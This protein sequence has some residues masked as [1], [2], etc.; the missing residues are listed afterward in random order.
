MSLSKVSID[1]PIFITCI[2]IVLLVVGY[3]SLKK[4]PVDLFPDVEIP[5]V[6]VR[7]DYEGSGPQ[8]IETQITKPMEDVIATVAGIETLR[9]ISREGSSTIIAEFDL[10]V[11]VKYAEQQIR[12]RVAA[13]KY[14]LPADVLDPIIRSVDPSD[15]PVI[16]FSLSADLPPAELYD[17]ANEVVKP[18]LTQVNKVGQV[19]ILGGRR[20]EIQVQLDRNKLFHYNL[21]A[22]AVADALKKAGQNTPIGKTDR[23]ES[24]TAYRAV[25]EFRDP[26]KVAKT[27]VRFTGNENPVTIRDV[28]TVQDTLVD[29]TSRTFVNG[30]KSLLIYVFRQSKA[31]TVAVAEGLK[32]KVEEI[33]VNMKG[34]PGAP[35]LKVVRDGAS[36]IRANIADVNESILIG[37]FL[38]II[39]VYFFLG[40]GRST[41]ITGLALPNSLLGA[42]ILMAMAGFSINIM[43]LLALSLTVG[44]LI[45][46]AI[47]VRENIFR[48]FEMGKSARR[49]AL[50][51]T[52]EVTLAV[53][54]TTLAILA[55]FGPIGFLSGIVGQ[56]LKEFGL[57]V[58]FAMLISLFDAL[59]IAPM[60]SAYFAR[61]HTAVDVPKN[62]ISRWNTNALKWFDRFQTNLENSY[63]NILH[64][65]LKHPL[66]VIGINVVIFVG[67]LM[68]LPLIPKTFIPPQ[69]N[70]EFS[71]NLD[72]PAGT[73]LEAM[74]KLSSEVDKMLRDDKSIFQTVLTVG[75]SDLQSNVAEIFIKLVPRDQRSMN[76]SQFKDVVREKLKMYAHA[77][78]QVSDQGGGSSSGSG[79]RPFNVNII[80]T[81]LEE[82]EKFSSELLAKLKKFPA[83][84]DADSS[85]R[86]GKPEIRFVPEPERA[87]SLGVQ[88]GELG[89]ELRIYVQGET[90]AVFRDADREYDV[91][92]RLKEDQRTLKN[93]YDKIYVPNINK[94]LVPLK[95]AAKVEESRSANIILRQDRARYVQI[96]GD[97]DPKG[98][99]IGGTINYVTELFKGELKPPAG[100][101]Y[102]FVGQAKRF[103]E[104]MANMAV[105]FGLGLLFIYMVLCSLYESFVTPFAIMLVF[106]LAACGAFMGLAATQSS[107]NLFSMIGCVML[108]GLATKNSIL[109]VD[110]ANQQIAKGS[111]LVDAILAAGHTRLRPILMTSFA[112]IAGMIPVAIGLNEASSQRTSMGI[113]IIGGTITSTL[114]SLL[115]VP[116][117]YSYIERFRI[118]TNRLFFKY[119][120]AAPDESLDDENKIANS[121]QKS[122]PSTHIPS[123]H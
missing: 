1:R 120:A 35:N 4:L 55:V 71:V 69:D 59:T 117:S 102:S 96:S 119:V 73:S 112:L 101:S 27:V 98:V 3:I 48:H 81:N 87:E 7:I 123:G 82:V 84:K 31:N 5:I 39:V 94:F 90:P 92:V 63:Q 10:K 53:I 50:E 78:P 61:H 93:D 109:L 97:L 29:E 122:D 107:L 74:S 14:R 16:V 85:F 19:D 32:K 49:S 24:E 8:E 103:G 30:E 56:Y 52:A 25:A 121:T 65:V 28:G 89:R 6:F 67:S 54:A 75:S 111:S 45:D 104:L 114:L 22:Q 77:N 38:T 116:A 64:W 86:I 66:K 62:I 58:C 43:S 80:G 68:L 23:G 37:I 95:A 17:L 70:G 34:K 9:S 44:L 33:N 105:A 46:D 12:D 91:R 42:F 83:L 113:A 15:Q 79:S 20:R 57:T 106:P 108:M 51:G 18:Q 47:V 11:D 100:V 99:G 21:S 118:W 72:L 88:T 36:R 115:V 110:Y 2:V 76:T 41:L 40:S 60:L 13:N 26:V